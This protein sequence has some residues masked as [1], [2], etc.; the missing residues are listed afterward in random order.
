MP[1]EPRPPMTWMPQPPPERQSKRSPITIVED[2]LIVLAIPVLWFTIFKLD[3][4]IYD[5]I[6]YLTLIMLVVIFVRRIRQ[7]R[8]PPSG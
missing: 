5:I 1:D 6:Q 8:T 7:F 2:I 3:G 4:A